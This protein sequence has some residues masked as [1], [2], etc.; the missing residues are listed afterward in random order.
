MPLA[1]GTS[2]VCQRAVCHG[3]DSL[4]AAMIRKLQFLKEL[5]RCGTEMLGRGVESFD[6]EAGECSLARC[7]MSDE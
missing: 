4:E 2:P 6:V 3:E 1:T 7:S 5:L